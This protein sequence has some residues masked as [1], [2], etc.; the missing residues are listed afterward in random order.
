[1]KILILNWRDVKNPASGGAEI[2]THEIAKRL[3]KKG[4]KVTL[5]TSSFKGAK[6]NE[7][8]DGVQ[9]IRKGGKYTVYLQAFKYYNQHFKGDFD[10]VIDE[11][12]TIPFFTPLYVKNGEKLFT[13]IHQ[14]AREFWFYETTIPLNL[15]GY[16]SENLLL[17][18]YKNTTT[19][20]VSISTLNDLQK[21]GFSNLSIITKGSKFKPLKK[22]PKKEETPTLI[23]VGRLKNPKKPGD[24]VEAFKIIKKKIK[25]A[26]LWIVGEGPL[27]KKLEQNSPEGVTFFGHVSKKKQAELMSKAH[28]ILVPGI[29]EGWGLVVIEANAMGTPAIGYNINGLRDSIKN[30]VNGF[31][32]QN[33]PQSLAEKAIQLIEN[34]KLAKKLSANAIKNS[35]EY[36]WN[37]STEEFIDFISKV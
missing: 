35:R 9:I 5:F 7:L 3:V 22:T 24:A 13:L 12:N 25:N 18:P 37:K 1:L 29:R 4:H 6:E 23:Y 16:A 31:L 10:V 34:K 2:L 17:S 33:N 20:T 28:A 11:I 21:L 36:N 30:G 19:L 14:L 27:R 26:R 32:T 15:L 8:I